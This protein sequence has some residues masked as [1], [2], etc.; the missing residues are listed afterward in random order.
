MPQALMSIG[1]ARHWLIRWVKSRFP[2]N[3]ESRLENLL[4][5]ALCRLLFIVSHSR[6]AILLS[7]HPF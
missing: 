1:I 6:E 3:D 7:K 5:F 2:K 4:D